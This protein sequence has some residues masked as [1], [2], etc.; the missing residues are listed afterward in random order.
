MWRRRLFALASS[1]LFMLAAPARAA[2]PLAD[3]PLIEDHGHVFVAG[4]I[5]G[6]PELW[7]A[8]DTGASRS[9]LDADVAA[10][11]HVEARERGQAGG[12]RG[13]VETAVARGVVVGLPGAALGRLDLDVLPL[14][15][16]STHVGVPVALVL[17]HELFSRFV[18]EFDY[19]GG[20][21]RLYEPAGYSAPAGATSLPID[22]VYNHPYV[23]ATA[24]SRGGTTVEGR[25]VIDLG[26]SQNVI[27]T[28]RSVE[29]FHLLEGTPTLKG[30]GGGLGGGFAMNLGRLSSLTLGPFTVRDLVAI[31][32]SD[33]VMADAEDAV[34]NLGGGFLRRF[35]VVF[36]YSRRRM[37]LLPNQR[38]A[39]PDEIDMSGLALLAGGTSMREVSIERVRPDSP[40]AAAGLLP[41]DRL[42]EVDGKSLEDPAL[43]HLRSLF[44]RQASYRVTVLRAGRRLEVALRTQRRI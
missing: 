25:F 32:P 16:L 11:L 3:L 27:F 24:R 12:A 34:G 29:R 41:G 31:M 26:S 15:G 36:D 43:P 9:V 18:V 40:A 2:P 22:L 39:E 28:P 8:L 42:V 6:T 23:R 20:R 21:M 38:Y 10:R 19:E 14:Q 4:T 44:S 37:L 35:N 17:G 33:G 5:A 1:S 30:Q 7:L 13:V